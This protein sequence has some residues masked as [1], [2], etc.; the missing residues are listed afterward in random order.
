[1]GVVA[2]EPIDT[3]RLALV[4]LVPGHAEEMTS[5]L[6]DPALYAFTG[7][8]PPTRE[9]LRARYERWAAGSPDR[10]EV[11]CNWVILLRAQ[12]CL[13]GTVQATIRTVGEPSAEVAWVLGV[14]WQGKGI[15]TEA[16]RALVGWLARQS[17]RDVVARIHPDHAASAAVAA[18]AGLTP[19]DHVHDGEVEW[20]L[21]RTP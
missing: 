5:V 18:A 2:A 14:P 4:P 1:V 8:V 12:G 9:E 21:P 13:T 6:S 20:R 15:A 11:W 10:G 19:T 16:A 7:G 3:G 17:V